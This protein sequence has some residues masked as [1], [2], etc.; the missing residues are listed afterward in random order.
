MY[1]FYIL[2]I[3]VKGT[4]AGDAR[5]HC[6]IAELFKEG[7]TKV[8]ILLAVSLLIWETSECNSRLKSVRL[9]SLFI[10]YRYLYMLVK[11]HVYYAVSRAIFHLIYPCSGNEFTTLSFPYYNYIAHKMYCEYYLGRTKTIVKYYHLHCQGKCILI[12]S[13]MQEG[14]SLRVPFV[15]LIKTM[16]LARQYTRD[17]RIER[18]VTTPL[19]MKTI[20]PLHNRERAKADSIKLC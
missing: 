13:G 16:L 20:C 3:T 14:T 6:C 1:H 11:V 12:A 5:S 7:E 4:K 15:S 9:S 17:T 10:S 8:C 2:Y 18:A 19:A